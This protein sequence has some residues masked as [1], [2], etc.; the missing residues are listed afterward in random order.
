M[1]AGNLAPFKINVLT[2]AF[3]LLAS[4]EM[5][6]AGV[7]VHIRTPNLSIAAFSVSVSVCSPFSNV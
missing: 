3:L 1:S 7:L 6:V 2:L 4:N 5:L